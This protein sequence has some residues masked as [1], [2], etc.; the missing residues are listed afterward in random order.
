MITR[1]GNC[2]SI[3]IL[4]SSCC[5]RKIVIIVIDYQCFCSVSSLRSYKPGKSQI[6]YDDAPS[7]TTK[8]VFG[9]STATCRQFCFYLTYSKICARNASAAF[10]WTVKFHWLH[11][12]WAW[13]FP[14]WWMR[15]MDWR[16]RCCS[17][18]WEIEQERSTFQA[19][20]QPDR[21]RHQNVQFHR[22]CP[23]DRPVSSPWSWTSADFIVNFCKVVLQLFYLPRPITMM[24][25]Q[26][27]DGIVG[28]IIVSCKSNHLEKWFILCN[29]QRF[30]FASKI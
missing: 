24:T 2:L 28:T 17:S 30:S 8:P 29:P 10:E 21:R 25:K 11:S 5:H 12:I 16:P 13:D 23:R 20:R 1:R 18:I 3:I 4:I 6:N 9:L 19:D 22:G 26:Q 15:L 7:L 27:M 14:S